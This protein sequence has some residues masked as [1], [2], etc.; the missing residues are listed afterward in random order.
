[1]P[2]VPGPVRVRHLT[3]RAALGTR[4]A[5]LGLLAGGV[6]L[7]VRA[8]GGGQGWIFLGL[9][10]LVCTSAGTL[11]ALLPSRLTTVID[12]RGLSLAWALGR[13]RIEWEAVERILIAP[14]GSGG[15]RDPMGV[16][17]LLKSGQEVLYSLLGKF[18]AEGHPAAGPLLEAARR[19]G[20]P[21]ED[22]S[23]PPAERSARAEA[24]RKARLKGWR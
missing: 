2:R 9:A 20:V 8:L 16:T 11:L 1:M 6:L 12:E 17:L 15:E 3:G 21:V 22:V 13:R 7:V 18:S 5:G 14:L 23:A 10:A 24:W 19:A 4:I